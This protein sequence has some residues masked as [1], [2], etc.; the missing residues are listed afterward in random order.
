[1]EWYVNLFVGSDFFDVLVENAF[2]DKTW[3]LCKRVVFVKIADCEIDEITVDALLEHHHHYFQELV[4]LW[5][6]VMPNYLDA[7]WKAL[8]QLHKLNH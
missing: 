2:E 5:V 3:K 8:I 7:R 1:M 6:N 4:D